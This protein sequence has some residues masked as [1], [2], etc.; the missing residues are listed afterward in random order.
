MCSDLELFV[1]LIGKIS[2]IS[3]IL[4]FKK[5]KIPKEKKEEIVNVL[6]DWQRYKNIQEIIELNNEY[7]NSAIKEVLNNPRFIKI[8]KEDTKID[9]EEIRQMLI[10]K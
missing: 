7:I 1:N 3:D 6:Y 2:S 10:L 8:I 9:I 4:Y 5:E